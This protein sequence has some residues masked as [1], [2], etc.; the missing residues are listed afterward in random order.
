MITFFKSLLR[1]KTEQNQCEG[2]VLCSHQKYE[3]LA[4]VKLGR[5]LATSPAGS[6]LI[7]P[8]SGV[9]DW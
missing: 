9:A 2:E 3:G 7:N 6:V 8:S 4:L 5:I 1:C